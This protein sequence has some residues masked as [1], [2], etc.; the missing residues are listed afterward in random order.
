MAKNTTDVRYGPPDPQPKVG[1]VVRFVRPEVQVADAM[2]F[3]APTPGAIVTAKVAFVHEGL[4][5]RVV[6]LDLAAAEKG[7]QVSIV[8]NVPFYPTEV[9]EEDKRTVYGTWHWPASA[10]A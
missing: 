7:E 1:D 6:N 3:K 2:D 9:M 5:G 8:S 10:R 4:E